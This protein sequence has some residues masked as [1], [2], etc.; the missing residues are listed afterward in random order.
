M[1][2][3]SASKQDSESVEAAVLRHLTAIRDECRIW[4]G[5]IDED[6]ATDMA[7]ARWS[8]EKTNQELA[9]VIQWF[10]TSHVKPRNLL[11]AQLREITFRLMREP[12]G[13]RKSRRKRAKAENSERSG[14]GR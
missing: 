1:S 4:Q 6:L 13:K 2:V 11:W 8:R 3:D 5:G 9:C 12:N 14:G 10:L 7:W